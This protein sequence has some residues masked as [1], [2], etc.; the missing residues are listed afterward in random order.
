VVR[1]HRN[2]IR[3][4]HGK[5][6][7]SKVGVCARFRD[8]KARYTQRAVAEFDRNVLA[9]KFPQHIFRVF[10]CAACDMWHVGKAMGVETV[11]FDEEANQ[12]THWAPLPEGPK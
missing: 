9:A 6:R 1:F 4:R 12:P 2:P 10:R 8:P 3:K 11:P 5:G 7:P